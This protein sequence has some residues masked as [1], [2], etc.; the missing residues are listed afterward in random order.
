MEELYTVI[1]QDE[2]EKGEKIPKRKNPAG[3]KQHDVQ[4]D[5]SNK[6]DDSGEAE[7]YTVA[8]QGQPEK[9]IKIVENKSSVQ[10]GNIAE[11]AP[12]GRA[13][14]QNQFY[15]RYGR[16]PSLTTKDILSRKGSL[17]LPVR[18]P[19]NKKNFFETALEYAEK[20]HEKTEH[21]TF[22][23]YWPSYEYM[24]ESQ[25]NWY[26]YLRGCLRNDEY[27]DTD[28]SYLFVYIYELINQVGVNNS[29]DGFEKMI[30]VWKN[31]RE[32]HDKL[33]R[34]LINWASDYI[35]FYNYDAGRAFE[36]LE[37]E[38]LFLL[39]PTDMLTE[40][41]IKS[42][43]VMPLELIVR[44]SDY[45]FY[46]SEFIRSADGN[47]FTDH[48]PGLF[49]KIRRNMSQEKDGG[50]ETRYSPAAYL[51]WQ[52]RAPFLRA[53]FD[54]KDNTR[55]YSYLPY[56]QHKPLRSFITTLAKEF[57]N[58]LRTLKKYKG[59][60]RPDKLPDEIINI[61]KTYAENA[62]NGAQPEQ[63]VEIKIDRGRLL[64][65]I[66]DSDEV[67]KKLIE[68]NF[69]YGI[70]PESDDQADIAAPPVQESAD[71]TVTPTPQAAG[72]RLLPDLS[73][74]QQKI[75][76]FL[77]E[78]GGGSH[79]SEIGAAF[80]GVFVGVEIDRINDAALEAIGDLL[81]A[82]ED[83]RWYIIEDYIDDL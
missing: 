6:S 5:K 16:P 57:E 2:P 3:A 32:T 53:P 19:G 46:E 27:I 64:A 12:R 70:E 51:K 10:N 31:Y 9:N 28:L 23:C 45:K 83:E 65:L 81:I 77:L 49:D 54:N 14:T 71:N 78:H 8:L 41:Y 11:Y 39:M 62:V 25:L 34:Y 67:R 82:Y 15:L 55:L 26:F 72:N 30:R 43:M 66:Q 68:G 35:N 74:V 29:D 4:T 50:F 44:F 7:L 59:R 61:C 20:T 36:L 47:L 63:N 73:P 1:F 79:S 18:D 33:D 21:I 17:Q 37:K 42:D 22:M 69:E 48:F 24:S 80:Q 76:D 58:Q 40:H 75:I 60:L 13:K 38:G 56:E 52:N